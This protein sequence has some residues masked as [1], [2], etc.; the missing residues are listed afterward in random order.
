MV[1]R[2]AAS[3]A[4]GDWA[5][6]TLLPAK[7]TSR[8]S[9]RSNHRMQASET[10]DR[11]T[12]KG[13]EEAYHVRLLWYAILR[14]VSTPGFRKLRLASYPARAILLLALL[15]MACSSPSKAISTDAGPDSPADGGY[16]DAANAAFRVQFVDPANGP[17][18]GGTEVT[19][20]GN[21]FDET[22]TVFVGGR[23]V[24][25]L[26][27]ELIDSRRIVIRTPPGEPGLADV[28]VR[29]GTEVAALEEAFSYEAI[30]VD[31]GAGSV[32]GGTFVTINGFGT[33]FGDG[34][35]VLFDGLPLTG[36][37]VVGDLVLTGITPVGVSGSADVEITT[38]TSVYEAKRG[39]TYLSTADPFAAGMGGGP[40][41]GDVNVVVLDA[42]TRNGIDD[43]FVSIGDPQSSALQGTADGLGQISFSAPDLVGPITTYAASPGYESAAFVSYDARDITI[44]LRRPP[45]PAPP[46]TL[47]PGPQSG[48]ILGHVLFGDATGLGSPVWNLVPEP[49]SSSEIKRVYVTASSRS[50]F[51]NSPTGVAID[52][53]GY[54]ADKTAWAFEIGARP[55]AT[56]V[57]ATAGLYDTATDEFEPFAMGV[58]RGILVGP[59]ESVV[60]IDLVVNIPLDTGLLVELGNPPS[61]NTPGWDG[62]IEYTIRPIIDLGGEGVI[63]MNSHGE[64]AKLP[65]ARRPGNYRFAD[66][67]DS[68]LLSAMAP[69]TGN[70]ADASYSFIAGAYST[71]GNAPYSVRIERGI[72][73]ISTPITIAD[74][75]GTPR[76]LDPAPDGVATAY[77]LEIEN[78]APALGLPTFH[79]HQFADE[80]GVQL[81]RMFA[82][83]DQLRVPLPNFTGTPA[84]LFPVNTDLTWTFYSIQIPQLSFDDFTYRHLRADYWSAYAADSYWVQFPPPSL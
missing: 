38:A 75:I 78:E 16:A 60:G 39:F 1:Y 64:P 8:E 18:A 54:D 12:G 47:P 22:V 4:T 50:L 53:Q 40:I 48:R 59:G 43:A 24:E 31:P 3:P 29:R 57:V 81:L 61:L 36:L 52:Y 68:I 63:I 66:G 58:A 69:L 30:F 79:L 9:G 6:A 19:V 46:G 51:S 37:N 76:P 11:R 27:Q 35:G 33:D 67:E 2:G 20:R 25:A 80:E 82:R 84:D 77:E 34:T 65:P 17:Y 41:A 72:T 45:P 14:L 83:G 21:D 44:L 73:E 7:A 5:T 23:M 13:G 32:T 49:R 62:P 42:N 70:L 56:A 55:S 15:L 74:F 71:A 28:E 26:D 10:L